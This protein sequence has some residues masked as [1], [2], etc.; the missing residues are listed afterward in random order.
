MVRLVFDDYIHDMLNVS[1][2]YAH[3]GHTGFCCNLTP[4]FIRTHAFTLSYTGWLPAELRLTSGFKLYVGGREPVDYECVRYMHIL[5]VTQLS[6]HYYEFYVCLKLY[7]EFQIPVQQPM[8]LFDPFH[9]PLSIAV[10]DRQVC[11]CFLLFASIYTLVGYS[12]ASIICI[13]SRA[14]VL[15]TIQRE[16]LSTFGFIFDGVPRSFRK[17]FI[18]TTGVLSQ[19]LFSQKFDLGLYSWFQLVISTC[20]F[21]LS[22]AGMAI[23]RVVG[24]GLLFTGNHLRSASEY[25]ED[26]VILFTR[27]QRRVEELVKQSQPIV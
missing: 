17:Q 9:G 16:L 15:E 25:R 27:L 26:N 20:T 3:V 24:N 6:T 22:C 11:D 13:L 5:L 7:T 1:D 2:H 12:Q 14:Q 8:R 21:R 19:V 10:S 18:H 4:A 23:V